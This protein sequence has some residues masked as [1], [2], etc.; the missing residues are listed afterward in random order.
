MARFSIRIRPVTLR[1]LGAGHILPDSK[2]D[3]ERA[4]AGQAGLLERGRGPPGLA[5]STPNSSVRTGTRRGAPV[6]SRADSRAPAHFRLVARA[7]CADPSP[8]RFPGDPL[9][10]AMHLGEE[11]L[12]RQVGRPAAGNEHHLDPRRQARLRPAICFPQPAASAVSPHAAAQP[13][14]HGEA[15]A[16]GMEWAPVITISALTGQTSRED[17][18]AGDRE[19]M[20]RVIEEFRRLNST[21]SLKRRSHSRAVGLLRRRRRAECRGCGFSI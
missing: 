4:A 13:P 6:G 15:H 9:D 20:K 18:A 21:I 8:S 1:P 2:D 3:T 16:R 17:S 14:A 7:S 5:G 11:P 19:P 10:D 12:E